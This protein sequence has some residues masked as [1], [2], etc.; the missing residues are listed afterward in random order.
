MYAAVT[1][2]RGFAIIAV[3][4]AAGMCVSAVSLYHHF[5]T[6]ATSYCDFGDNFNCDVVNRSTYSTLLGIPVAL[7]GMAGY[8]VILFLATFRRL[9]VETPRILT[10]LSAIGLAFALYLTYVEK[11]VLATW[12]ILC[13]TSLT[14]IFCITMLALWQQ[15][16]RKY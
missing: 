6:S 11:F 4:A 2:R 15:L 13:L 12:C 16:A 3:L 9:H 10:V 7:I 8:A 5:G 14:L 1:S